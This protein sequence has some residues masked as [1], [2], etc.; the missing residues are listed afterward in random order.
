MTSNGAG[1][2]YQ[3]DAAN[4]LAQIWYGPIG[5]S[6]STA[7]NYNGLSQRVG[8]I[9]KNAGGTVTC[10]KQFVWSPGDAGPSEERDAC[11][12]VTRRFYPQGEQI[13]GTSYFYTTDHLGSVRELTDVTGTNVQARYD[14]DLWGR[15]TKV[16]GTMDADFGYAGYYQYLPSGLNLTMFRGYDPNLGRW[17]SRDPYVDGYGNGAEIA[18]SPNLYEYSLNNPISFFDPLGLDTHL[19]DSDYR[20]ATGISDQDAQ[21]QIDQQNQLVDDGAKTI[22]GSLLSTVSICY[23]AAETG[24][25]VLDIA[26]EQTLAAIKAKAK[27]DALDKVKSLLQSPSSS[28]AP[29]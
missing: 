18:I 10:T 5:S 19:D 11:D 9:E 27:K 29:H 22:L 16:S 17:L 8:I 12:N 6:S 2:S 13:S 14:Y 3:W 24:V 25:T 1:Q 28:S 4:R 7:F 26:W 20:W 21:K 23:K 15:E